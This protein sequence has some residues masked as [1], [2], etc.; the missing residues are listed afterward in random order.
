[1]RKIICYRRGCNRP[2]KW[3]IPGPPPVHVCTQC[4]KLVFGQSVN[5]RA[6]RQVESEPVGSVGSVGSAELVE[7]VGSVVD[8][9]IIGPIGPSEFKFKVGSEGM[10]KWGTKGR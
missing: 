5:I 2:A 7:P 6:L 3:T 9:T 8:S 4:L 1:M 10:E